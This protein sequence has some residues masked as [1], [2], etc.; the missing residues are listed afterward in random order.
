MHE[1]IPQGEKRLVNLLVQF[2]VADDLPD[3]GSHVDHDHGDGVSL[4][5]QGRQV[6]GL[7]DSRSTQETAHLLE[8]CQCLFCIRLVAACQCIFGHG[9]GCKTFA[10]HVSSFAE[11]HSLCRRFKKHSSVGIKAMRFDEVEGGFGC[12]QPL[13]VPGNVVVCMAADIGESS[14]KPDRFCRVHEIAFPVDA[15]IYTSVYGIE[16]V[17]QPEREDIGLQVGLV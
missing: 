8:E 12:I 1:V 4:G 17:R 13:L 15:G 2:R 7:Q 9:N 11:R 16:S 14:L 3:T 10:E 6:L 5:L